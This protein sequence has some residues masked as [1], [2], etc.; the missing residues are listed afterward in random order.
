MK[1]FIHRINYIFQ[2][3]NLI[4]SDIK[5]LN[6]KRQSLNLTFKFHHSFKFLLNKL[7]PT[8]VRQALKFLC[9]HPEIH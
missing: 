6:L 1:N 3:G 7:V 8:L 5:I 2:F 4:P 9:K